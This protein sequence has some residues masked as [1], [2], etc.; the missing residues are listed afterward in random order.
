MKS[1]EIYYYLGKFQTYT[2]GI[3]KIQKL[4]PAPLS[5]DWPVSL[6]YSPFLSTGLF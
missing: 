2:K 5:Y 1:F 3:S 6:L 4:L